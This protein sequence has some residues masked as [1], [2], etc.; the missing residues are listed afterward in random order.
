VWTY[1]GS[2]KV[3]MVSFCKHV[4]E[5]PGFHSKRRTSLAERHSVALQMSHEF[6]HSS[7]FSIKRYEQW[8]T[9]YISN[10]NIRN[11][12]FTCQLQFNITFSKLTFSFTFNEE[13]ILFSLLIILSVIL[14]ALLEPQSTCMPNEKRYVAIALILAQIKYVVTSLP[15]KGVASYTGLLKPKCTSSP[16]SNKGPRPT[17]PADNKKLIWYPHSV[18]RV[19]VVSCR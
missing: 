17:E 8:H 4:N 14:R 15:W 11:W 1:C 7:N 16:P 18:I 5:L 13:L 12:Y 6:S 3:P 19:S 9:I 10:T 2:E